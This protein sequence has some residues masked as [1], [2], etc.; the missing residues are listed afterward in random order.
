MKNGGDFKQKTAV[1]ALLLAGGKG[2]RMRSDLPK[3][4]HKWENQTFL[5]R[6]LNSFSE[7]SFITGTV[8]VTNPDIVNHKDF[9]TE[10]ST[11][12]NIVWQKNPRGTADAVASSALLYQKIEEPD[13]ICAEVIRGSQK[14]P[15]PD[16]FFIC[17]GDM[18]KLD[19]R[20]IDHFI[21]KSLEKKTDLDL[22]ALQL[23]EPFS[24]GRI[25]ADKKGSI[26]KIVEEK[27]ATDLEKKIKVCNSSVYLVRG[28]ELFTWL[29][30]LK[31]ENSSG[32]Y[33][34]TDIVEKA[35]KASK[36][37]SYT[38]CDNPGALMGVNRPEDLRQLQK[39]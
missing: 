7:S 8:L 20:T 15:L 21:E 11:S 3:V 1:T 29:S 4:L 9:P 35:I 2:T 28:A 26:L 23:D 19:S 36:K 32:E 17:A 30:E 37:V 33:Y 25:V 39:V 22:L 12:A 18:P 38:V 31:N 27:D 13:Y 16:Y 24:Y 14:E 34:L 10:K 5:E 6:L